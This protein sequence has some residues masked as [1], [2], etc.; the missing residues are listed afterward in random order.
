MVF[1]YD[2][3]FEGLLTCVF[4]AYLLKSFP[5][6]LV[7]DGEPLPMFCDVV[8]TVVTDSTKAERVWN[9][10]KKKLS[11]EALYQLTVVWMA[12]RVPQRDELMMR[13]IRKTIDAPKSIEVNFADAD[14]LDL[15]RLY[16]QVSYE[17][18]R[19]MQ[20][21]RFQKAADGTYYAPF[22]PDHNVLPLALAH[23]KDRFQDQKWLLY[24]VRRSYGFYYDLHTVKEVTFTQD[25]EFL[26]SGFLD[27]DKMADDEQLFQQLWKT[28]FKSICIKERLNPRKHKQ[29][30][31]VRYWKFLTE[32]H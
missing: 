24:D 26:R 1:C 7:T 9:G 30:M 14:V 20:F 27:P 19:V 28:Y 31:P 32:K 23:F 21:A 6:A 4:D 5:E 17:R 8:W 3:S 16:K 18:M 2:K 15:S 11:R 25:E 10:L 12:D 13:Y 22:E 29:D